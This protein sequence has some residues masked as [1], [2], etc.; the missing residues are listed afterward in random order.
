MIYRNNAA[1]QDSGFLSL[2]IGVFRD[3]FFHPLHLLK[4]SFVFCHETLRDMFSWISSSFHNKPPK[5]MFVTSQNSMFNLPPIL[6]FESTPSTISPLVSMQKHSEST[7]SQTS[8]YYEKQLS[9]SGEDGSSHGRDTDKRE[10]P[11]I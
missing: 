4:L 9:T 11:R 3:L 10:T 8:S 6:S 2:L 1:Q 7:R 5:K